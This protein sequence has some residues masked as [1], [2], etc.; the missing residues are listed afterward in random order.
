MRI[1]IGIFA[2]LL[3]NPFIIKLFPAANWIQSYLTEETL[4]SQ[5]QEQKYKPAFVRLFLF[6]YLLLLSFLGVLCVS[7]VNFPKLRNIS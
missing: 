7:V 6:L 2:F 4:S 1:I 3:N 5:K